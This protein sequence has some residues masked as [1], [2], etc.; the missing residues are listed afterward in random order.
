M[1]RIEQMNFIDPILGNYAVAAPR[2]VQP[3][4]LHRLDENT[5]PWGDYGG[6]RE[7]MHTPLASRSGLPA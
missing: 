6:K 5:A 3:K 1:V 7:T 4:T 2:T